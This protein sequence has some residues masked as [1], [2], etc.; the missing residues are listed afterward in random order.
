MSL[1]GMMGV[2]MEMIIDVYILFYTHRQ[3]SPC[4]INASSLS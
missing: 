3:C 2:V 4:A 1:V